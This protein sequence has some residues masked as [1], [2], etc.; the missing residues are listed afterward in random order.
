M[1]S[2]RL[3]QLC[4]PTTMLPYPK[5]H[6]EFHLHP[7]FPLIFL[8]MLIMSLIFLPVLILSLIFL[9][10]LIL[11]PSFA[12]SLSFF[13]SPRSLPLTAH[14]PQLYR[15]LVLDM[16]I[17]GRASVSVQEVVL[18]DLKERVVDASD[19]MCV[20]DA[21][22][23][24]GNESEH[25]QNESSWNAHVRQ[26][27]GH[28]F[29]Q[30]VGDVARLPRTHLLGTFTTRAFI[31]T[32]IHTP[33]HIHQCLHAL[34]KLQCTCAGGKS[35]GS[36]VDMETQIHRSRDHLPA[37][38][39]LCADS[40]ARALARTRPHYSH[41][42]CAQAHPYSHSY[43]HFSFILFP[44]AYNECIVAGNRRLTSSRNL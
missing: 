42:S 5:R 27:Q 43:Q 10:M 25:C 20:T 21:S 44:E 13:A 2:S 7:H 14:P 38:Q 40:L 4:A 8:P 37:L 28:A 39:G 33:R 22:V 17:W 29:V 34:R 31:F 19:Y 24:V 35:F 30:R 11:S 41:Y 36:F 12:S 9:P 18:T 23:S 15:R 16:R 26:I 3:P 6:N 32:R 1:R